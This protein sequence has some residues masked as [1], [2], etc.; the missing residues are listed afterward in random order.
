M[1]RNP[2]QLITEH[3]TH[4]PAILR[5]LRRRLTLADAPVAL[6]E[7]I[8]CTFRRRQPRGY[9]VARNERVIRTHI[10]LGALRR[11]LVQWA[12]QHAPSGV[13]GFQPLLAWALARVDWPEVVHC[14][15]MAAEGNARQSVG[16]RR[17][18]GYGQR[19]A[20]PIT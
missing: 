9:A 17:Y 3:L 16:T 14:V 5:D 8:A 18:R 11:A 1:A 6:Q 12:A 7:R 13:G 2:T 15:T 10:H 20:V 4:D 19:T